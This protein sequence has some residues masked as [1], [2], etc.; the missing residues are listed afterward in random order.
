MIN[1]A[2]TARLVAVYHKEVCTLLEYPWTRSADT[3]LHAGVVEA[4]LCHCH[5]SF[6]Q[7]SRVSRS[8]QKCV[9]GHCRYATAIRG[10]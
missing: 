6:P 5:P 2:Q 8:R 10:Q 4:P 1:V 9:E 3:T 7:S